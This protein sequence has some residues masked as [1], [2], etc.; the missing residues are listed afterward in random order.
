MA[1]GRNRFVPVAG[2]PRGTA[3]SAD[4]SEHQGASQRAGRGGRT[5]GLYAIGCSQTMRM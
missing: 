5:L 1:A 2:A 3:M 4:G